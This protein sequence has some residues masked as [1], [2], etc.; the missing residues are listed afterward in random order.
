MAPLGDT[1]A[2]PPAKY[3]LRPHTPHWPK[4]TFRIQIS[5]WWARV[6]GI[7]LYFLDREILMLV[8]WSLLTLR[9][10]RI[11]DAELGVESS[12]LMIVLACRDH[13]TERN[14]ARVWSRWSWGGGRYFTIWFWK[15][16]KVQ[17]E[18]IKRTKWCTTDR[19]QIEWRGMI[20]C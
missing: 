15:R 2:V 4:N 19:R 10:R 16:D 9:L 11:R 8:F 17:A 18:Y 5:K 14:C 3:Q 1:W 20:F 12:F 13:W 6:M 7:V